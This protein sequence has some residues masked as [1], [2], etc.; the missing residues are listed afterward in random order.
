MIDDVRKIKIKIF[1]VQIRNETVGLDV[2]LRRNISEQRLI[3]HRLIGNISRF[4]PHLRQRLKEL[5]RPLLHCVPGHPRSRQLN[6][7]NSPLPGLPELAFQ[8]FAPF[9]PPAG[10]IVTVAG[11]Q[12]VFRNI[13]P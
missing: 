1:P 12:G 11:F 9:V 8:Y 2:Q 5:L 10:K 3:D 7:F 4:E 13:L 6:E